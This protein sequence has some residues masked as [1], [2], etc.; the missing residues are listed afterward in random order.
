MVH[1]E[2]GMKLIRSREGPLS[3]ARWMRAEAGGITLVTHVTHEKFAIGVT[4]L[5]FCFETAVVN[6][7]FR[8]TIA[9]KNNAFTFG[10]RCNRLG[11]LCLSR[12]GDGHQAVRGIGRCGIIGSKQRAGEQQRDGEDTGSVHKRWAL[13]AGEGRKARPPFNYPHEPP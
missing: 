11:A 5:E 9:N 7:T 12:F 2:L 10:R 3:H 4:Q 8:Q 6:I 1:I 13:N